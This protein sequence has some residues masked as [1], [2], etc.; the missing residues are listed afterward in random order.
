MTRRVPSGRTTAWSTTAAGTKVGQYTPYSLS[1]VSGVVV[2][3]P[4]YPASASSTVALEND[5]PTR[6]GSGSMSV[7]GLARAR[8]YPALSRELGIDLPP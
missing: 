3:N 1:A 7:G 2:W 4:A 8:S 5:R 6:P